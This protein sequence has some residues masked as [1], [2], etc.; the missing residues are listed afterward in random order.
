SV[1]MK[2]GGQEAEK[3]RIMSR[4]FAIESAQIVI[5]NVNKILLGSGIFEKKKISDFMQN[6]SYDTLM[7]SYMNVLTDMDRVAD[8][9]FE[10]R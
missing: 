9:L 3:I 2:N 1:L 5:N 8:I 4:I 10:R 6:I 7:M